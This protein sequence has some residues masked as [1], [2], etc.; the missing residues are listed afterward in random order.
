MFAVSVLVS[1]VVSSFA[2]EISANRDTVYI[3]IDI[4]RYGLYSTYIERP[5]LGDPLWRTSNYVDSLYILDLRPKWWDKQT[6]RARGGFI[7]Q[8]KIAIPLELFRYNSDLKSYS[9]EDLLKKRVCIITAQ[10]WGPIQRDPLSYSF[11]LKAEDVSVFR[12]DGKRWSPGGRNYIDDIT[13]FFYEKGLL[14]S[15]Q[16]KRFLF[17]QK[18]NVWMVIYEQDREHI[19]K[20]G[21]FGDAPSYSGSLGF[22]YEIDALLGTHK[23]RKSGWTKS[24][25]PILNIYIKGYCKDGL[26]Y[27]DYYSCRHIG[28][29]F[30]RAPKE[31]HLRGLSYH[32]QCYIDSLLLRVGDP[33]KGNLFVYDDSYYGRLYKSYYQ[34]LREKE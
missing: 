15:L 19:I 26:L 22:D 4:R 10:Q 30:R 14:E 11:R 28:R 33:R 17:Y 9:V 32:Q 25:D 12:I 7:V 8:R 16:G 29:R 34:M 1:S 20:G 5:E 23:S 18:N 24:N 2:Q 31:R 13:A 3:S 21:V 6:Q 27:Q